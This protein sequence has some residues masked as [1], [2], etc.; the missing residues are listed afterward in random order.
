MSIL[1]SRLEQLEAKVVKVDQLET[2]VAKVDQHELKINSLQIEIDQLKKKNLPLEEQ[3]QLVLSDAA[4]KHSIKD[5]V[6]SRDFLP[7]S[8]YEIKATN[9][10]AQSGEYS[11]DPDGQIGGDSPIQVY[12]DMTTRNSLLSIYN[13]NSFTYNF[14]HS[15]RLH[16]YTTTLRPKLT[17]L[18]VLIQGATLKLLRMLQVCVS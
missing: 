7:R 6:T 13:L 14:L 3:N 18:V 2:K 12:C 15:K 1:L 11:I 8:C 9:P 4:E 10:S 16:L 17:S 5:D